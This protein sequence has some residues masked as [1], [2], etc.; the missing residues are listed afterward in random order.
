VPNRPPQRP[1]PFPNVETQKAELLFRHKI[2]RLLR[3]RELISQER[4]DL[5]LSW[6]KQIHPFRSLPVRSA[7]SRENRSAYP[8]E[9]LLQRVREIGYASES[10]H[11]MSSFRTPSSNRAIGNVA[12]SRHVWGDAAHI[13][14]DA[15]EDG[16]MDDL[17]RDGA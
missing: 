10:F 13:F 4:I 16:V 11:V 8:F 3:D 7:R 15:D 14:I 5:L 12:Y 17:N 2:L 9:H 6:R 1:L